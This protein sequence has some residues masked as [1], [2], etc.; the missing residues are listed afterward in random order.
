MAAR[1]F[2]ELG[3]EGSVLHIHAAH[4]R[5]VGIDSADAVIVA[6]NSVRDYALLGRFGRDALEQRNFGLEIVEIVDGEL[7]LSAGFGASGLERGATGENKDEVCAPRAEGNPESVFESVAVGEEQHDR[8][9]APRHAEH[10]QHAASAIV[11]QRVVGLMAE[12][13]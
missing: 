3:E 12:F 4:V 11:F 7:D 9:D 5:I 1:V 2:V 6:A 13:D 10:G 8:R